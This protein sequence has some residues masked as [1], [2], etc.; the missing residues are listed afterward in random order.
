MR[1]ARYKK[2][3]DCKQFKEINE[4]YKTGSYCK[5]CSNIRI[6]KWQRKN[7]DKVKENNKKWRQANSEKWKKIQKESVKKWRKEN[8]EKLKEIKKRLWKR[9]SKND[10]HFKTKT[11][12]SSLLRKRIKRYIF[13]KRPDSD[14]SYLPYSVADLV[15]HIERQ[16]KQGMTWRNYG[17]FGWQIDHKTP[18]C[19]FS[20][21]SVHD[22]GF[23]RSWAL[24][25]LQPL[26]AEENMKKGIKIYEDPI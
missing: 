3:P 23:Q 11:G 16:F 1:F 4:F 17:L 18:D 26:W 24:D 8:P 12:F 13:L 14:F 9:K 6:K 25:N 7:P 15:N 19:K 21:K 2:C 22:K 5:P 10:L 20:Y